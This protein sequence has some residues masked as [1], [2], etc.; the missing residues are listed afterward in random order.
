[1]RM[2]EEQA[3]E[4][5][6]MTRI[7]FQSTSKAAMDATIKEQKEAIQQLEIKMNSLLVK[8]D[9]EIST[10]KDSLKAQ[11]ELRFKA[12]QQVRSPTRMVQRKRTQ[13]PEPEPSEKPR[14]RTQ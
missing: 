11:Q 8:H 14:T 12:E 13:S 10:L 9:Q 4:E 7:N 2:A 1:M 5:A 3:H 6:K